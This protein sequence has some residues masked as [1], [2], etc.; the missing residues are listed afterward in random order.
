MWNRNEPS[1]VRGNTVTQ[2]VNV[3]PS[4][5]A[6]VAAIAL[7]ASLASQAALVGRS[8]DFQSNQLNVKFDLVFDDTVAFSGDNQ[9]SGFSN[10]TI[11]AGFGSA[12]GYVLANGFLAVSGNATST[13]DTGLN[14]FQLVFADITTAAPSF[15]GVDSILQ[16]ANQPYVYDAFTDVSVTITSFTPSAP[17]PPT[18][19]VPEPGTLALVAAAGCIG[20]LRRR[21]V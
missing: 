8:V 12:L 20:A 11:S 16:L 2:G 1:V 10:V 3:N 18:G 6:A 13:L 7:F 14:D 4:P 17:N 15:S 19:S 5:R 9:T 21:R